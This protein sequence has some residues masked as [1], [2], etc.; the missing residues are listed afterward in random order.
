LKAAHVVDGERLLPGRIYV[1]PPDLHVL[2]DGPVIRLNHGPKEHHTRPAIDP[3]F[4]SAALSRAADVI[5]V[6][7]TGMLD[8]GTAG[9]QAVKQ[10]GGIAVVQDPK[11]ASAPSMPASALKYVAVDYCVSVAAMAGLLTA[12]ARNTLPEAPPVAQ[13]TAASMEQAVFLGGDDAMTSFEAIGRPSGFVCPDC[14]GSLSEITDSQPRRYRCHTGHAFTIRTLENAQKETVDLALWSALRSLQENHA[15]LD[16][17][18]TAARNDRDVDEALRLETRAH[19]VNKTIE[20]L[21]PLLEEVALASD[22]PD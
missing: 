14:N 22:T 16:R 3:L 18:A 6:I 12:L 10:Y 20:A 17:M 4:R 5:G 9:L 11:E 21:R 15:L 19:A 8:D 2:I 7:L 1:A 13:Q